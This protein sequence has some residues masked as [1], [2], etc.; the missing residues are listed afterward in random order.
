MRDLGNPCE[1]QDRE[2]RLD[3]MF[4]ASDYFDTL[5][6]QIKREKE[7]RDAGAQPKTQTPS[8]QGAEV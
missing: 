4:D 3:R 8:G 1:I 5:A 6:A 2:D 7:Q